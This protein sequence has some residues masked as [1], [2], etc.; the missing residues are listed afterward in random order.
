LRVLQLPLKSK[1]GDSSPPT[2]DSMMQN[3]I[4]EKIDLA[5]ALLKQ[6]KY[7]EAIELLD[8]IH[9]LHP[10]E[11]S[12]L[13]RLAWAFWDSGYKERSIEYWEVLL[14]RELT[15]KVFTGFAYDELV[16]IYKQE[17]QI[18]KLVALCEKA[19]QVQAEDV[20]LLEELGKAYLLSG[21]RDKA[22]AAFK[23]LTSLENDNPAFYCRLGEALMAAGET[24]AGEEAFR[25]AGQI[26]PDEADRYLFQAAGL[27]MREGRFDTAKKLVDRCLEISP[28]NS[29]YYCSLGDILI[30]LKQLNNAFT[31]YETACLH[32]RLHAAAYF[33]RMGNS[34]MKADFFD[35]AIKAFETALFLDAST[36]CRHNLAKAYKAAGRSEKML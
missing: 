24:D 5:D 19:T 4:E 21:Q 7:D 35:S 12:V 30:A 15:R 16:R 18:E 10:H 8:N 11:E 23:K 33:N 1:G 28:S 2:F 29:L 32:D 22:C 13:L 20:G 31:A 14:D 3:N 34:L 27:H 17:G 26:D 36:P 6:E 9:K 25:Q